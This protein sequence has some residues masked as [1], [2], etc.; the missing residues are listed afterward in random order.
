MSP[1]QQ[2]GPLALVGSGEYLE[3]MAPLERHLLDGRAP[4]YVQLAT[5][6]VPD[7]PDVVARWHRLGQEQASRLGVEA[8]IVPVTNHESA[9]DPHFAAMVEGAGLIY[10]S[11]GNPT[12]LA[13]TLRDTLVWSAI[14]ETWRHGAALAGCSAGAMALTSW[15]PSLR[16]PR[17]GG[18]V[19]LGLLAHL[20]VIPHFDAFAAR[21]PDVLTRFLLPDSDD[22]MLLGVDEE[23][24]LVG[25]LE[26]WTVWGR[27]SVWHLHDGTRDE[28]K[29]GESLRT[30]TTTF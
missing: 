4:R 28:I 22:T 10:L 3:V 17:G 15:V 14:E 21:M 7:G 29:P 2:P 6:A 26:E 18:T 20:R 19:G 13:D 27:Q 1:S 16:H 30:P 23:T 12:Y 8:V 9:N 5:A 11:G 24:A 25:G